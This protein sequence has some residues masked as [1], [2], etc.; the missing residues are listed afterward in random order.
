MHGVTTALVLF[1]LA[2][3]LFPR[4]IANRPQYYA[5]FAMVLAAI[6]IDGVAHIFDN[7][8]VRAFAYLATAVL[9][10]GALLV[11]F[12]AA[13]GLTVRGLSREMLGAFE[14]IRRGETDSEIIIP[15]RKRGE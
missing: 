14:V 10:V 12:L 2:C 3:V 7:A 11:L 8:N 1:V 15:V 9:Q 5:G 4:L 13:G 6:L